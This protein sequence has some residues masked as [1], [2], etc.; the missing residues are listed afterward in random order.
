VVGW[1]KTSVKLYKNKYRDKTDYNKGYR[2]ID[3]IG[4][5]YT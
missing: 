2:I 5:K 4:I 1:K 3:D